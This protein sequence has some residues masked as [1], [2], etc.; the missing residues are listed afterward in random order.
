MIDEVY[1]LTQDILNKNGRG[2]ITPTR[3]L[4]IAKNEQEKVLCNVIDEYVK[5]KQDVAQ[6]KSDEKFRLL[7]A[8]IEIFSDTAPLTRT[9]G[10]TV[11]KYHTL[12]SDYMMWGNASYYGVEITKVPSRTKDLIQR[13]YFIKPTESNPFCYVEKSKLYVLPDTIG[14]ITDGNTDIAIDEVVVS[15]YRY[16][17]APNW[18]YITVGDKAIFNPSNP[19]YQDFELPISFKNRLVIGIL[20]QLG[21][22]I[23]DEAIYQ[24]T[25]TE[26]TKEYQKDNAR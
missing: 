18:T 19:N 20:Q 15:Y 2:I 25:T 6:S 4:H 17:K 11:T 5:A 7:D 8:V 1:S 23:R 21:M 14:V 24:Y 9:E 12:P 22:H 26:D 16:P 13:N 10:Q 3:F